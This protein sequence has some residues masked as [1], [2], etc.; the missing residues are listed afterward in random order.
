M[1]CDH[2]WAQICTK[3]SRPTVTRNRHTHT[4]RTQCVHMHHDRPCAAQGRAWTQQ[5][6]L[7]TH[8]Q[9]PTHR[10][11]RQARER[12]ARQAHP[13]ARR[14]ELL[15]HARAAVSS[16]ALV[17]H[18]SSARRMSNT[19]HNTSL[20]ALRASAHR[21]A[22]SGTA[23][24]QNTL[25]ALPP[26]HQL[27]AGSCSGKTKI[28]GLVGQEGALQPCAA[29]DA[30][31]AGQRFAHQACASTCCCVRL[32]PRAAAVMQLACISRAAATAALRR[33]TC[34]GC[35]RLRMR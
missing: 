10:S 12:G 17:G 23:K 9:T 24:F 13:P 20:A 29:L 26:S 11:C 25:I 7:H 1:T 4:Q 31:T 30:Q 32:Q 14:T 16:H 3:G 8:T 19:V 5:P 18:H 21:Q 22:A 6:G 34:T 33:S 35:L 27:H 15:S 28:A 2:R